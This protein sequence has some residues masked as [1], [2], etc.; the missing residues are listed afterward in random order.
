MLQLLPPG[1]W[2]FWLGL[3]I[4]LFH[5]ASILPESPDVY[6]DCLII[7]SSNTWLPQ[8]VPDWDKLTLWFCGIA[9]S[10]CISPGLGILLFHV[11]VHQSDILA[12]R[13]NNSLFL[14]SSIFSQHFWY[15]FL[16]FFQF[17]SLLLSDSQ[18]FLILVIIFLWPP[19]DIPHIP[20]FLFPNPC[21]CTC[22]L[23]IK[24][25]SLGAQ[26]VF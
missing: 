3:G 23:V 24:I 15:F 22:L 9:S 13:P 26:R 7:H 16:T 8:L 21:L 2:C 18:H 14:L 19:Y 12:S 25:T 6:P 5:V 17:F 1:S 4:P 10:W 11:A 20:S